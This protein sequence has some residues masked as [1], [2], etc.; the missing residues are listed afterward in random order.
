MSGLPHQEWL[1]MVNDLDDF[2]ITTSMFGGRIPYVSNELSIPSLIPLFSLLIS[3]LAQH[4]L[5]SLNRR[6]VYLN[7]LS[8]GQLLAIY[9][10]L[11][12]H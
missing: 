1:K 2:S 7:P 9:W 3:S 5:S 4:D 12:G 11:L 10:Y 8:D 6:S